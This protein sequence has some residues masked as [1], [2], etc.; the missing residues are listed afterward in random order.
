M[1][2]EEGMFLSWGARVSAWGLVKC[3]PKI[4]QSGKNLARKSLSGTGADSR[5]NHDIG[6]DIYMSTGETAPGETIPRHNCKGTWR[7]VWDLVK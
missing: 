1:E 5:K 3:L 6:L 7:R 2:M 4:S